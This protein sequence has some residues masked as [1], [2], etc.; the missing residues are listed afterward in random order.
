MQ[1]T[2]INWILT[3]SRESN[4]AHEVFT[5]FFDLIHPNHDKGIGYFIFRHVL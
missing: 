4:G 2:Q 1:I 3:I 5:I